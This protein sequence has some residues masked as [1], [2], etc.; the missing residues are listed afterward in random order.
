MLI[1]LHLD[2]SEVRVFPRV[3]VAIAVLCTVIHVGVVVA[4]PANSEVQVL[5]ERYER[6]LAEHPEAVI[7]VRCAPYSRDAKNPR[8]V[9]T[10]PELDAACHAVLDAVQPAAYRRFGIVPARG[11]FQIGFLSSIFLHGGWMH[12]IGNLLFLYIVGPFLEDRWGHRFFAAFFL[13]GGVVSGLTQ[14]LV[15]AA[16]TRPI[17]G[18]SGAIAACMGAFTIL[19]YQRR[20]YVLLWLAIF[21]RRFY[22]PAWLWG[23][24]WIA[25]EL[26]SYWSSGLDSPVAVLVHIGGFFFGTILAVGARHSGLDRRLDAAV[27]QSI[28]HETAEHPAT[29][30]AAAAFARNDWPAAAEAWARVVRDEPKNAPALYGATRAYLYSGDPARAAVCFDRFIDI[31]AAD[32]DVLAIREAFRDLAPLTARDVRPPTARRVATL[33]SNDDK[34]LAAALWLRVAEAATEPRLRADAT[35]RAE[36][37]FREVHDVE[38]ATAAAALRDAPLAP[39]LSTGMSTTSLAG[40][41]G[42]TTSASTTSPLPSPL[43]RVGRGAGG[44]GLP[45]STTSPLPAPLGRGAGGEGLPASTMPGEALP[46]PSRSTSPLAGEGPPAVLVHDAV[47]RADGLVLEAPEP[48]LVRFAEIAVVGA[49]AVAGARCLDLKLKSGERFR[50]V[51]TALSG[52]ARG[53]VDDDRLRV[54][55]TRLLEHTGARAWPSAAALAAGRWPRVDS[56]VDLDTLQA[57]GR[58]Q[59]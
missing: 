2:N 46:P 14:A 19:F 38:G 5:A 58:P 40:G 8:R 39:A 12:L 57:S 22:M 41:E 23:G 42:Q 6:L 20:V 49:A 1:P 36:A 32:K 28:T 4:A 11:V 53:D 29:A 16:S 33:V 15:D 59:A 9:D 13:V 18:A 3:C 26:F 48:R 51:P 10:V 7:P 47:A 27:E 24:F 54:L 55:V 30:E 21:L 52:I 17:I 25:G 34:P 43:E 31:C 37:L 45:A 35:N 44:E 56:V 50:L